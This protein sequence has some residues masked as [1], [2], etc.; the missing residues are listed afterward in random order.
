MLYKSDAIFNSNIS[1]T[2]STSDIIF[3][4]LAYHL[5]SLHFSNTDKAPKILLSFFA[6]IEKRIEK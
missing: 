6:P 5:K 3:S 1:K 4:F 2:Y